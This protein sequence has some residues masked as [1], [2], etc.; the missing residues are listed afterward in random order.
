MDMLIAD[1]LNKTFKQGKAKVHAVKDVS[2]TVR[3]GERVYVHGPS[4]AGKSTL[5]H[6]IG[7]LDRPSS[8]SVL[9]EGKDIYRFSGARRSALRN[10]SFGF[11]FQFYHLLPELSV[12]EN[13]MLPAAIKARGPRR[14]V[15]AKAAELLRTVGLSARSAHRPSELSGGEAQ[16]AAIARALINSPDVLFCDEPAGNLDSAMSE[17]VYAMIREF[18]EKNG[19]SVVVISHQEVEKGFYHSE[20]SMRDGVL[21]AVSVSP[22]PETIGAYDGIV[23]K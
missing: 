14:A 17:V 22:V 23:R 19:M 20:Y 8:G 2:L 9:F 6:M 4:G 18:S 11:V 1:K 5:L 3:K 13:V 21:G 16:R 10:V 12:L 15:K 7:G